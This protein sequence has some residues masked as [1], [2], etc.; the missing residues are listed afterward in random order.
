MNLFTSLKVAFS[1]THVMEQDVVRRRCFVLSCVIVLLTPYV[2]RAKV[3]FPEPSFGVNTSVAMAQDHVTVKGRVSDEQGAPIGGASI[4]VQGSKTASLTDANGTYSIRAPKDGVLIF[5]SLGY[6]KKEIDVN[7]RQTINTVLASELTALD[8]VVVIGYQT[9][10]RGDLTGAVSSVSAKELK[11]IPTNSAAEAL[12]GRLAGVQVTSSEGTPGADMKIVVRGGG[13]ITQSNEPLYIIDGLE[14]E[15]GLASISPRDIESIDVLKDA[16]ATAIYGARGANGVV[17]ITTKG[18]KAMKTRVNYDPLL[19]V[20]KLSNQLGVLTPYQFVERQYEASRGSSTNELR[21]SQM[22]GEWADIGRF[23]STEGVD[24]QQETFGRNA[25]MQSHAVS[26]M[27]GSNET[28]FNVGYTDSK[29]DGIML[30]SDFRRQQVNLR[31]DHTANNRLR[32]GL[33]VRYADQLVNG[34]GVSDGGSAAYSL[35]R[36]T[37]KYKPILDNNEDIIDD[38]DEEYYVLTNQGNALG[39]LNPIALSNAMVRDDQ[40]KNVN[41]G[42]YVDFRLNSKLSFR[43]TLG[44]NYNNRNRNNFFD[45][46]TSLSRVN[47]AAQPVVRTDA[48]STSNVNFYNVAT[49]KERIGKQ[50]RITFLV[51]QQYYGLESKSLA[52]Q[53]YYFPVGISPE[54]A[55]GQLSLGEST[56]LYPSTVVTESTL[57]SF[58]SNVDYSFKNRYMITATLRSDGSSK[59]AADKRWG[60]FPAGAFAW[61]LSEEEFL[62]D[63][64]IVSDAKLRLSY[65]V[66]GNNRIADY[67]YLNTFSSNARYALDEALHLGYSA[68][69]LANKNLKWETTT[70]KNIGLDLGFLENRVMLTVDAY[71]N[72]VTDLLINVPIPSTTGYRTQLQNVGNTSNRGLEFQLNTTPVLKSNFSWTANFNLA[73]NRNNVEKLASGLDSYLPGA[74]VTWIS[75]QPSDYVVEVG[76]PVGSMF[77]FISDGFYKVSDFDYDPA[78]QIYTPKPGVADASASIGLPQPG[79]MKLKD[80]NGDGMVDANDRTIIGNA[81]PKFSGGLF[82]QFAYKSF[83]LSVFL[84]FVY[85]NSIYNANKIE[86]TNSYSLHTNMLAMM[87]DRWKTIDQQGNRTQWIETV[88]GAQVVKGVS[89]QE[90]ETLNSNAKIWIPVGGAG[91]FYPTSWAVEDGS[92]LRINNVT[93]GYTLPTS[94]ANRIKVSEFRLFLTANNL[95]I[96]TNYSGYD[97]DVNVRSNPVTPGVDFSAY[98]RSRSFVVGCNLKL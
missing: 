10:R 42:G 1:I 46:I 26:V 21:F 36:H 87:G 92:Y 32:V 54:K 34:A 95:A 93:L 94:L 64:T 23:R 6:I 86:F 85:G 59:F 2:V 49:Y 83:D 97:P 11:D 12:A 74:A 53:L 73:F 81:N 57:L 71:E 30:N 52:N 77:G 60:Y 3:D 31:F 96:F 68:A 65:G 50:H 45:S 70:S 35:L 90:L 20:R 40:R 14:V 69:A 18:G 62:K 63:N 88:A 79:G 55:F 91:Q 82:Q 58:F 72:F 19:G 33:N 75:G 29:E 56:P 17:V 48:T 38:V 22:Y 76:Q 43:S 8:E 25:Q 24:W 5:T 98:P 66:S 37:I 51:G 9:V 7:G 47:G 13:S 78:T 67:L 27:G 39:T 16:A 61:R 15:D 4:V 89:P 44:L 80:V 84:N 41:I 28:Q